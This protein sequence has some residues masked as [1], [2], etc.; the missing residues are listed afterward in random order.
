M[1]PAGRLGAWFGRVSRIPGEE[2]RVLVQ[3]AKAAFAAVVAWVLAT[4]VLKLPQPFLA[5]Y[6]AVFLVEATVYRS[7]RGFAQQV[8]SVAAGVV[9]AAGVATAIPSVTVALGVVVFVGLV[10]GSWRGLGESGV[11]VGLTGLLL[12]SYGSATQE[13][14]LVDRLA[15]TA[16]GAGV[17]AAVNAVILPPLYG[18]RL[19]AATDRLSRAFA[20]LL[21]STSR[22]MCADEDAGEWLEQAGD[23]QSLVG[24][25]EDAM[26][27]IREG[28]WLNLRRRNDRSERPLATLVG[29]WP[30]LRQLVDAFRAAAGRDDPATYPG[31]AARDAAAA[32][33]DALADAVRAIGDDHAPDLVRCR[34]RLAEADRHLLAPTGDLTS[35]LGLGAILLPA[36]QVLER[37][38]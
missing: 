14:L 5:P 24:A 16:L 22:L 7:V 36:R 10:I 13:S 17:G 31:P 8:A 15:E 32:L 19:A 21:E 12:I 3:A 9:L 38:S 18:E 28:R 37:L 34:E 23:A 25:A 6:A 29:V 27:W 33:L 20:R 11:W 35:T 4:A 30:P 2:R 1:T 26:G